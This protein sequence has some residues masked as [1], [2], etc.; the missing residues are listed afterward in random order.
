MNKEKETGEK[1]I[2]GTGKTAGRSGVSKQLILIISTAALAV[3]LI[4]AY[5]AFIKPAL[6]KDADKT[7]EIEL[8]WKD[9]VNYA[10]TYIMMFEHIKSEDI[11]SVKIHNPKNAEKYG[12]QYVDWGVYRYRAANDPDNKGYNEGD[13]YMIGF[14]FAAY[15]QQKLSELNNAAGMTITTARVEDHCSDY[16]RYGLAFE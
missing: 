7:V 13:F 12:Q 14:E 15:D 9:E 10:N 8:I 6:E 2:S 11:E 3:V 1:E 16:S 4:I 5:F